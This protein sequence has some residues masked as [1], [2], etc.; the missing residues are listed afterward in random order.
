MGVH[1]C[2][3]EIVIVQNMIISLLLLMSNDLCVFVLF[4][5]APSTVPAVFVVW[6]F[7]C[8]LT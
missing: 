4:A 1:D 8:P 2:S 6:V 7:Q 3:S 5:H